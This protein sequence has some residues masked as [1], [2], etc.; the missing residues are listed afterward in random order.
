MKRQL[1]LIIIAL[2]IIPALTFSQTNKN[3]IKIDYNSICCG[4][5]SEKPVMEFVKNFENENKLKPFEIFIERGLGKEGEHTFYIGIDNLSIEFLKSFLDG[6]K[7]TV[8]N[9]NRQRVKNKDGYVNLHDKLISNSILKNIKK[10]PRTKISSLENYT[11]I[12]R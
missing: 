7:I 3:Y 6:L 8:S 11:K 1:K 9:Q 2:G 10:K 5:P 4:T 12:I